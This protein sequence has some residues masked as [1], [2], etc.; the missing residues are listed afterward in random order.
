MSAPA[1]K[2]SRATSEVPERCIPEISFIAFPNT[3]L[4]LSANL[5]KEYYARDRRCDSSGRIKTSEPRFPILKS[6]PLIAVRRLLMCNGG[7]P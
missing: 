5:H 4:R 1:S 2:K 7:V 6:H 3:F